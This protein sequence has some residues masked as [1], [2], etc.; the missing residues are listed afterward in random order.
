MAAYESL[1]LSYKLNRVFRA[2][3]ICS[4]R[5]FREKKCRFWDLAGAHEC[6]IKRKGPDVRCSR[7]AQ[8]QDYANTF[9]VSSTI[10][11]SNFER[12]KKRT[13][14]AITSHEAIEGSESLVFARDSTE[15][16]KSKQTC[17][18]DV[19][20][21]S[22]TEKKHIFWDSAKLVWYNNIVSLVTAQNLPRE[23]FWSVL[24]IACR[25]MYLFQIKEFLYGVLHPSRKSACTRQKH[26]RGP[27]LLP[28]SHHCDVNQS[29]TWEHLY[30]TKA[31]QRATSPTLIPSLRSLFRKDACSKQKA[32]QR[33]KPPT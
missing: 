29:W 27:I 13:V 14:N 26:V 11:K 22:A 6:E 16:T 15:I 5:L 9:L 10:R 28:L 21:K 17:S 32:H 4:G 7:R 30:E 1:A 3:R 31:F 2:S 8:T 20:Q 33:S 23:I 12:K 19:T 25:S 18:L 24:R